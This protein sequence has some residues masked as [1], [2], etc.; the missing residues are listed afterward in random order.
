V[1]LQAGASGATLKAP[2]ASTDPVLGISGTGVTLTNLTI[3]GGVHALRGHAG[4]NITGN[5]LVIEGA[6]T[7]N[8]LMDHGALTLNNSTI[9]NSAANGIGAD[10]SATVT[11]NGGAIQG[12]AQYGTN[13]YFTSSLNVYGGA[14]IQNNGI[15]GAQT[16]EGGSINI[17]AATV[18]RNGAASGGCCGLLAGTGGHISV[19]GNSSEIVNNSGFGIWVGPDSNAKLAGATIANNARD[20]LFVAGGGAGA[21]AAGSVISGN[22]GSGIYSQSGNI[23]VGEA[24]FAGAPGGPAII[25]NNKGD[26]IYLGTN[27]VAIFDN[28]GNQ[29]INN[30]GWGILCAGSPSHPVGTGTPGTVTGN[31]AGQTKCS[32]GD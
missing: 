10:Y 27:S 4:A 14:I 22:G 6:S 26:G 11:V 8:V 16:G 24:P 25:E 5:N 2:S 31:K 7:Y 9:E 3:S 29:I 18:Q 32:F 20:G 19:S 1:T 28:S 15:L 12:N 23:I 30:T 17:T 21:V 13:I